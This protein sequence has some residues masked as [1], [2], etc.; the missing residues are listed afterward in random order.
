MGFKAN[1]RCVTTVPLSPFLPSLLASLPADSEVLEYPVRLVGGT[2]RKEGRVEIQY[3]GVWG[4]I[5]GDDWDV[6][7]ASVVCHQL[8]YE[9]AARA[10]SRAEF[11]AGFGQI[12][13]DDVQCSGQEDS[14]ALCQFNG[15]GQ[16]NCDHSE[17]AGVVCEGRE[18]E[19]RGGEG[20]GGEGRGGE[21]KGG[22]GG[23][24]E[25]RTRR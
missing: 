1:V 14:L 8:G 9:R 20:R 4:T 21:G 17:D 10:S 7:D 19:G 22:E 3:N 25:G 15:W 11:G 2:S 12:W 16:H 13:M 23:A 18:E 24:G 6:T 5:C